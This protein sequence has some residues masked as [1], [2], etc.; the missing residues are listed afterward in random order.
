MKYT[1]V[2]TGKKQ[3]KLL[4]KYKSYNQ[5]P[6]PAFI[7]MYAANGNVK[8]IDNHRYYTHETRSEKKMCTTIDV[9]SPTSHS[10]FELSFNYNSDN[11]CLG[12]KDISH[13]QGKPSE[14]KMHWL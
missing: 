3:Q 11:I 8:C 7:I 4:L 9:L 6:L 10:A 1:L 12:N 5:L 13:L 14:Q 2:C